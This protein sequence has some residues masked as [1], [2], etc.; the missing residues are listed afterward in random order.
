MKNILSH[1]LSWLLLLCSMVLPHEAS[2]QLSPSIPI[3]FSVDWSRDGSTLAIGTDMGLTI[4]NS[5]L[6]IRSQWDNPSIEDYRLFYGLN[7]TGG[8]I[9]T[10]SAIWD[11]RTFSTVL[12][13]PNYFLNKWSAD[14][15]SILAQHSSE[16]GFVEL[17]SH[18]G[19]VIRSYMIDTYIMGGLEWSPNEQYFV[20][21]DPSHTIYLLERSTGQQLASVQ[22]NSSP[23]TF[24]W[25][26]NS[27]SFVFTERNG[28]FPTLTSTLYR[29][30]L[31][32][33]EIDEL[34]TVE[35]Y[36]NHINWSPDGQE[37]A[38]NTGDGLHLVN[39]QSLQ[40]V[41]YDLSNDVRSMVYSPFGAQ[42]V[43]GSSQIA[44]EGV[45]IDH[46]TSS[47]TIIADGAV[48]ILV[49][50]PSPERL[51]AIAAA[52]D[53]PPAVVQAITGLSASTSATDSP[54]SLSAESL[55]TLDSALDA[56]L[57]MPPGCAADLRA[58]ADAL[59]GE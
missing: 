39:T 28:I 50:D 35:G 24:A 4:Y 38:L 46:Q 47:R 52:C 49:P 2:A 1:A 37:W 43:I 45:D 8:L 51:A 55:T 20:L 29:F 12:S 18:N 7:S 58:V 42:L 40:V 6:T 57:D 31:L 3:V 14:D 10:Q 16:L 27:S 22:R 34:I 25:H 41:S 32:S 36:V 15:N 53:A 5:D 23:A 54:I 13:T 56:A 9:L 17:S 48:Q 30:N 33:Y 19:Q 59:T 21:S 44:H 26:P 11:T